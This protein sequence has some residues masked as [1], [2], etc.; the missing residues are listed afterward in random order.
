M[1]RRKVIRGGLGLLTLGAIGP[2]WAARPCAPTIFGEAESSCGSSGS[3]NGPRQLE[4]LAS[5][6]TSGTWEQL[7]SDGNGFK[8]VSQYNGGSPPRS[9]LEYGNQ[10]FWNSQAKELHFRGGG[11]SSGGGNAQRHL[12]YNDA[13]GA[14]DAVTPWHTTWAHQ[15]GNFTGDPATGDLYYR[16]RGGGDIYK[17]S[18]QSYPA[19]VS[20]WTQIES[21][22]L[23]VSNNAQ[24]L[25]FFPELNGGAGGLVFIETASGRTNIWATQDDYTTW[26]KVH[27]DVFGIADQNIEGFSAYLPAQQAVM[28]GGGAR[29]PWGTGNI[30]RAALFHADGSKQVIGDTPRPF[31]TRQPSMG[32]VV[33]HPN[34][35]VFALSAASDSLYEYDSSRDSWSTLGSLP[36]SA[37]WLS[38]AMIPEFNVI[39]V[40]QQVGSSGTDTVQ[41]WLYK[42]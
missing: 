36:F 33:G 23:A 11:A 38:A 28:F 9:A 40:I 42:L 35:R 2:S 22:G 37:Y 29:E 21:R 18:Y 27:S 31:G 6:A 19:T 15:W 12:R 3:G 14:W 24:C 30:S 1:N 26:S 20:S 13:V 32:T 10:V 41:E 39:Y 16:P 8:A 4:T 17:W 5:Q 7:S 34:G 25:E